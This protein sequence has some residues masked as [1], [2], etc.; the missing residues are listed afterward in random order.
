MSDHKA[1]R[2]TDISKILPEMSAGVFEAQINR[3]LSDVAAN[4]VTHGK[5]GEVVLKFKMARIG[6]SH[7]LVLTHGIKS[8]VPQERGKITEETESETPFHVA[9]G[10]ALELFPHEQGDLLRGDV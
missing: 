6:N 10:G 4:V 8:V 1:T 9:R 7:Q 5:K 3:A 2:R